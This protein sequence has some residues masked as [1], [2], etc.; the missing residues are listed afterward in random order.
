MKDGKLTKRAPI[1]HSFRIQFE[2]DVQ[3]DYFSR[4]EDPGYFVLKM[5]GVVRTD[6]KQSLNRFNG[7]AT[8]TVCVCQMGQP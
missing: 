1:N 3:N 6:L 5:D 8:L 2:T 7:T 4:P